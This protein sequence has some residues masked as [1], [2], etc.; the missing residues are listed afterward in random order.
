M[1]AGSGLGPTAGTRHGLPLAPTIGGV[2]D[3]R[4]VAIAVE[5]ECERVSAQRT[6][7]ARPTASGSTARSLGAR[8]CRRDLPCVPADPNAPY[9]ALPVVGPD[10]GR[11]CPPAGARARRA[12]TLAGRPR[13]GPGLRAARRGAWGHAAERG[14]ERHQR[15][16]QHAPPAHPRKLL[17]RDRGVPARPRDDVGQPQARAGLRA[18][19]LP[20]AVGTVA[21]HSRAALEISG[22][23]SG[24]VASSASGAADCSSPGASPS[25]SSSSSSS[26][27]CSIA[28]R[29]SASERS[30]S[31]PGQ[32]SW[33]G[34]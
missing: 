24:A 15:P 5:R 6:A 28:S 26:Q 34:R 23:T 22:E 8:V 30:S 13:A 21:S 29:N 4:H 33:Q 17:G 10:R 1:L 3:R 7:F 27:A 31:S 12:R 2:D 11:A 20:E 25:S 14:D 16:Q 9:R 18:G 32:R 19:H